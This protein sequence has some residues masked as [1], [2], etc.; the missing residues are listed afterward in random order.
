MIDGRN[1]IAILRSGQALF[2]DGRGG[3]G[4]YLHAHGDSAWQGWQ[5]TET[6][7]SAWLLIGAFNEPVATIRSF[8]NQ[9][10]TDAQ[11]IVTLPEVRNAIA[12]AKGWH[13]SLAERLEAI[14]R[15][16]EAVQIASGKVPKNWLLVT[17][18]D[19][20]LAAEQTDD[21]IRLKSLFDRKTN[22]ELLATP[23]LPLFQFHF[24]IFRQSG[25]F[26]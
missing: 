17:A 8:L 13:R 24:A 20:G 3:Y 22:R 16:D 2:H 7:F 21:G 25:K 18:G 26:C 6:Q 1:V 5:T 9:L 12:K 15:F 23:P 11:V 14:G 4:T 19:L 10:P